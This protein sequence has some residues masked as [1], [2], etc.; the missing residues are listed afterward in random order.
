M[1]PTMWDPELLPQSP[2]NRKKVPAQPRQ[3]DKA[4][5]TDFQLLLQH[6]LTLPARAAGS[7]SP[8]SIAAAQKLRCGLNMFG[9]ETQNKALGHVVSSA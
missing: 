5:G 6:C 9:G 1:C 7:C 8:P 2:Q 3:W 4:V